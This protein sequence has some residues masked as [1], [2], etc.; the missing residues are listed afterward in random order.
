MISS[1]SEV[2][3]SRESPASNSYVKRLPCIQA[4]GLVEHLSFRSLPL[5][6]LF[7]GYC[8]F[9]EQSV[10]NLPVPLLLRLVCPLPSRNRLPICS[11]PTAGVPTF[12]ELQCVLRMHSLTPFFPGH[13]IKAACLLL[14]RV[15]FCIERLV[16]TLLM[17]RDTHFGPLGCTYSTG[18]MHCLYWKILSA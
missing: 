18:P 16:I 14:P 2:V 10:S 17:L 1:F 5:D 7:L 4:L 13:L 3:T 11:V 6:G 9:A 8:R 12:F 15:S